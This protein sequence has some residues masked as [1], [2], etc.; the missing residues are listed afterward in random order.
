[1]G[2]KSKDKYYTTEFI[3]ILC[4]DDV[5]Y[6]S[7]IISFAVESL[8]TLESRLAYRTIT[9]WAIKYEVVGGNLKDLYDWCNCNFQKTAWICIKADPTVLKT[10]LTTNKDNFTDTF[11]KE[12]EEYE[13]FFGL[14][15]EIEESFGYMWDIISEVYY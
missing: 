7:S 2:I 14:N 12:L 15:E 5:G 11:K 9:E 13:E 8:E 6:Y 4:G 1:M 10:F 3:K